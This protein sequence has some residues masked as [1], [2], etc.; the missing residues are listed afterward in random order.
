M[1]ATPFTPARASTSLR[2]ARLVGAALATTTTL[3]LAPVGAASADEERH[4]VVAGDTVWDL[5]LRYGTTVPAIVDANGLNSRALIRIGEVLTIPGATR[6]GEGP[7]AATASSYT[8]VEGDTLTH[9]ARR[10]GT[11]IDAIVAANSIKDPS[12]IRI[13]QRLVIPGGTGAGLVG[14]TFAGRTYPADVVA[15][16]NQNKAALNAMTV[17]S[18]AEMQAMVVRIARDMGVDPALAQAVAYQ[19]SGFNQRAVSPANAIGCMQVIPTSGEWASD[20]VGRELD[21]LNPEDNVTAGIA[22]L[23]R[24]QRNGTPVETALAG[25]YQGEASV[26]KRGM[27]QDTVRYVASVIALMDRFD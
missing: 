4:I 12:F 20:I 21:L 17:P 11:S 23:K 9:I 2:K 6:D 19:E 15:A 7:A 8:V 18:R 26:K 27:N 13:G 10:Y 16:A 5:A 22:I 3:V 24:L 1:D 14:D 25:Y